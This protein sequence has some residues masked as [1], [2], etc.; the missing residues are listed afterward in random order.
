MLVFRRLI[1]H[2]RNERNHLRKMCLMNSQLSQ[3]PS[4][5]TSMTNLSVTS[6]AILS[7][8]LMSLHGGSKGNTHIQPLP[9]WRWTTTRFPV[10]NVDLTWSL[11]QLTDRLFSSYISQRRTCIQQRSY[12]IV[13]PTQP[14]ISTINS[15][16]NVCRG[17]EFNGARQR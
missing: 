1:S 9:V 12:P 7:T 3:C 11:A 14:T 8:L 5:Q 2:S 17:M 4:H 10:C 15:R 13:T 16:V 6:I